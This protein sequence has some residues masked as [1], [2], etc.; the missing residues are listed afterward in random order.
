MTY[1]SSHGLGRYIIV[2]SQTSD[3]EN[4]KSR[5]EELPEIAHL[6]TVGGF[7]ENIVIESVSE[8]D[9][10]IGDILCLGKEVLIQVSE[11]RQPC[12]CPITV[13]NSKI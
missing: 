9:I 7:G 1:L 8:N 5:K 3:P 11:P 12:L 6:F 10:C 2:S 13:L 4:Y